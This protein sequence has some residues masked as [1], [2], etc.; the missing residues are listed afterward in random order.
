MYRPI[1]LPMCLLTRGCPQSIYEYSLTSLK[2][3][4]QL[5]CLCACVPKGMFSNKCSGYSSHAGYYTASFEDLYFFLD[6]R[7]AQ[8]G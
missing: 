3:R 8:W 4:K 5:I 7:A 6:T 2:L 1:K